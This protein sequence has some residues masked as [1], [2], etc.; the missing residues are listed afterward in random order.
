MTSIR[1]LSYKNTLKNAL[2]SVY[3]MS[4]KKGNLFKAWWQ[5]LEGVVST[6]LNFLAEMQSVWLNFK[7]Y[8][9]E[10]LEDYES[11]LLLNIG[12]LYWQAWFM[13]TY[14]QS[15]N[16]EI[17]AR[18]IIARCNGY[19]EG[20]KTHK[21]KIDKLDGLL[22]NSIETFSRM[23]AEHVAF[24]TENVAILKEEFKRINNIYESLGPDIKKHEE[25]FKNYST[26]LP[27]ETDNRKIVNGRRDLI[28]QLTK[29]KEYAINYEVKLPSQSE[30]IFNIPNHISKCYQTISAEFQSLTNNYQS[31]LSLVTQ[32]AEIQN[33]EKEIKQFFALNL[34]QKEDDTRLA[35]THQSY[36]EMKNNKK[37]EIINYINSHTN[38]GILSSEWHSVKWIIADQFHTIDTIKFESLAELHKQAKLQLDQSRLFLKKIDSNQFLQNLNQIKEKFEKDYQQYLKQNEARKQE[39]AEDLQA[40]IK[41]DKERIIAEC[42]RRLTILNSLPIEKITEKNRP[43]R[44]QRDKLAYHLMQDENIANEIQQFH[45][46]SPIRMKTASASASIGSVGSVAGGIAAFFVIASNPVGWGIGLIGAGLALGVAAGVFYKKAQ[47]RKIKMELLADKSPQHQALLFGTNRRMKLLNSPP[48]TR[49]MRH[50]MMKHGI[51]VHETQPSLITSPDILLC[52]VLNSQQQLPL[53]LDMKQRSLFF[54]NSLRENTRTPITEESL[55]SQYN[56][57]TSRQ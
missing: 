54:S 17:E 26:N 1:N 9:T 6:R 12:L 3:P 22:K 55:P 13:D 32:E 35:A 38:Y 29:I 10:R 27:Y 19:L 44:L 16:K 24:V 18:N 5:T 37:E 39:V 42:D 43:K 4:S 28:A 33:L 20:L 15:E 52:K 51:V 48:L 57:F 31:K 45:L 53:Y 2:T 23:Q 25:D 40:K 36:Q 7:A 11:N 14:P 46:P 49:Y 21:S 8:R 30:E 50:L 34:D 41:Q 56:S 47:N